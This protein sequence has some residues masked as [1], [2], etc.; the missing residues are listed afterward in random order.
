[1]LLAIPE[2]VHIE[3]VLTMVMNKTLMKLA[4]QNE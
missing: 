3:E 4:N 1:M 2:I